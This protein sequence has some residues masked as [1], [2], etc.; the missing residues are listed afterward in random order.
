MANFSVPIN[1]VGTL[2]GD[3]LTGEITR[4]TIPI[5][6]RVVIKRDGPDS[7]GPPITALASSIAEG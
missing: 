5:Q 3:S 1:L 7:L 4:I 6:A 2:K